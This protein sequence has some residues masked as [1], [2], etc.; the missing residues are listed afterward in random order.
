M[1]A[2]NKIFQPLSRWAGFTAAALS[3]GLMGPAF[4]QGTAQSQF[5]SFAEELLA[6]IGSASVAD[7]PAI[8]G[9]GKPR[10][11]VAPFKDTEKTIPPSVASEF[12]T[13]LLAELTRRGSGTYRF[14]ARETLREIIRELD[15]IEELES[16]ANSRVVDLL[17]NAKVDILIV[18]ALRKDGQAV[19][20]SYK[21]VSV[22]DGIVF[23]ATRPRQ[24]WLTE[25]GVAVTGKGRQGPPAQ[26]AAGARRPVLLA[27]QLL[28][29]LD[30]DPGPQD[31]LMRP[32]LRRAIRTYQHDF[33]QVATGRMTR[34]L[35][36][37]LRASLRQEGKT[38]LVLP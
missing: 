8:G 23:A 14:V 32:S 10:I 22:E 27:Q 36:H 25:P 34:R 6:G 11:A 1:I 13:R 5:A 24:I 33:G 3:I 4:A 15:T 30:Y 9:Y 21:A 18:G 2:C 29:R 38:A 31:G 7:I 20:I 16:P 28:A 17:R 12:N 19:S 37:E 35:I 26:L